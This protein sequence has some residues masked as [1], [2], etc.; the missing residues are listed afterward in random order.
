MKVSRSILVAGVLGGA[1]I[2]YFGLNTVL[3]GEP[4]GASGDA[5]AALD[6]AALPQVQARW[7]E[8]S[9]YR[10]VVIL[11]G[12]TQANR[13]VELR[14]ESAGPLVALPKDQGDAVAED[15]VIC[16]LAVDARQ[17]NLEEA[18]AQVAQARLEYEGAVDLSE[19]GVRSATQVAA[20][21]ASLDAAKAA[22]ARAEIEM[23]RTEIR[24]PFAGVLNTRPVEVGDFLQPGSVCGTV[25]ELDPILAVA[26]ASEDDIL[27]LRAGQAARVTLKDGAT[28]HG[29]LRYVSAEANQATR[30][31]A[32][33]VAADNPDGAVRS[34]FTAS[35]AIRTEP[36]RAHLVSPSILTLDDEGRVAVRT[37]EGDAVSVKP[38]RIVDDADG[39]VWIAGLDERALVITVS[40]VA[41]RDGA[42]V[43]VDILEQDEGAEA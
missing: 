3:R 27:R 7:S 12:R 24:A 10:P 41:L 13:S 33:E 42:K 34:G 21:K 43:D 5:T 6:E 17:A 14:A 4:G 2:L 18:R 28:R 11:R 39:G 26:E 32:I 35:I 20:S 22:L 8:A 40:D 30:T 36:V 9:D 16:Q 37:V 31:F 23:E 38:V 19:R 25:V 15:D 29:E 1:I